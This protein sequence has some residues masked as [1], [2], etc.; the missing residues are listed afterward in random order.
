MLDRCQS[1][2]DSQFGGNASAYVSALMRGGEIEKKIVK[3][4]KDAN[5]CLDRFTVVS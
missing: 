1:I 4:E 3:L 2:L 5:W